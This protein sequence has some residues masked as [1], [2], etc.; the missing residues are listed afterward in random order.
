MDS[1]DEQLKRWRDASII[2]AETA[3]R[4]AAFERSR[5]AQPQDERPSIQEA[6][7]YLGAAVVAVGVFVLAVANWEEFEPAARIAIPGVT[8][9][10]ALLAG[11]GLRSTGRRELERGAT[12]AWLLAVVLTGAATAV[13]A[14]ESDWN[15]ENAA[16]GAGLSAAALA[17]ALWA[18]QPAHAQVLGVLG[19]LTVVAGAIAGRAN[20]S[21]L[22]IFGAIAGLFAAA[23][24]VLVEHGLFIPRPSGRLFAAAMLAGAAYLAGLDDAPAW[25]QMLGLVAGAALIALSIYRGVFIYISFG[26]AVVFLGLITLILRHVDNPTTAALALMVM[27]GALVAGVLLLARVRPWRIAREPT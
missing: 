21:Q 5:A 11:F 4:I 20:D 12:V 10:L 27:G 14:A 25:T 9:A 24:I 15:A 23:A 2:D 18:I 22:M 26:V 3:Q 16:L 7:V 8:A 17:L 6:L 1:I 13:I 19:S